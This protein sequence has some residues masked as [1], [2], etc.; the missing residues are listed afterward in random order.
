MWRRVRFANSG[1]GG[2]ERDVVTVS[3]VSPAAAVGM[4]GVYRNLLL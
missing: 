1:A 3:P 2:V 4:G